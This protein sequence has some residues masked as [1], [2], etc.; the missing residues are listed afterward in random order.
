MNNKNKR[1]LKNNKTLMNDFFEIL[2]H[3]K[4]FYF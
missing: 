4:V 2:L 3:F 1:L